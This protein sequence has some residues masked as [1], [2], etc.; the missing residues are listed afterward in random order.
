MMALLQVGQDLIIG[1]KIWS[2][3]SPDWDN[4]LTDV[5][6]KLAIQGDQYDYLYGEAPTNIMSLEES[7][8]GLN[9]VDKALYY[10]VSTYQAMKDEGY[11]CYSMLANGYSNYPWQHLL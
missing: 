4:Y 2:R 5:K 11:H 3:S 10:T 8:E 1:I 7:K 9:S 6:E